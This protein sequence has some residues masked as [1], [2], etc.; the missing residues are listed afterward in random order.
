MPVTTHRPFVAATAATIAEPVAAHN[1]KT[2]LATSPRY[3]RAAGK[4]VLLPAV[5]GLPFVGAAIRLVAG[6]VALAQLDSADLAGQRLRQLVDEL[7]PP[8]VG[9]RRQ[10]VADERP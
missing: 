1:E 2:V 5:S 8:R 10:A 3:A 4:P 7:D 6:G 9:V